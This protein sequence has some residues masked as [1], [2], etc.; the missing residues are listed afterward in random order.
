[1]DSKKLTDWMQV[2]GIFALVSSLIFVGLQMRQTQKI[3]IASQFQARTE[4]TMNLWL[5]GIEADYLPA[6]SLRD[7]I[8]ADVTARDINTVLWLWNSWDSH[9]YQYQAGFLD[10]SAWQAVLR[11]I[12]SVYG[13]C[14]RRFIYEWRKRGLRTEFVDMI[15]LLDDKCVG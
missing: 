7:Q 3:A 4:A 9:Y 14:D 15:N 13:L 11:N 6:R 5:V 8:T 10:E 1:V 12:Q 2:I